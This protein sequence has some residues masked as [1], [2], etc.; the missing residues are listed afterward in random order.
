VIAM[1]EFGVERRN[2]VIE[3][4]SGKNFDRPLYQK[5][6]KKLKTNDTLVIKS[7]DRLGRNYEEIL[8]QWRVITKKKAA[9]IVVLDMPLLDTR[10]DHDLTG[11]LIADI[12]L[13]LLSYVAQTE[14]EFIH[15][16]QREGIEAAKARGVRFGRTAL[17]KPDN[18]YEIYQRWRERKIS[19]REASRLLGVSHN[20]F[21]NWIN[22]E[23]S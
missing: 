22:K 13:Q 19:G 3:K 18:Y 20:T 1:Q 11:T 10:S 6:I 17:K 16:R 7:I 21:R 2:I 9:N 5:L 12:V 4:Q 15:Q 14:R 8:E 23:I